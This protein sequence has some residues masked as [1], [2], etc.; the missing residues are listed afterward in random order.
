MQLKNFVMNS[1]DDVKP[2]YDELLNREVTTKEE[3]LVWLADSDEL[4]AHISEDIS[5]RYIHQS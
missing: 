3:T 4:S 2:Y 1:F 5:R